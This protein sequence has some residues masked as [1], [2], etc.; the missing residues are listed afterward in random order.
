MYAPRYYGYRDYYGHRDYHY[1][2]HDYSHYM[3]YPRVPKN[4]RIWTPDA[5]PAGWPSWWLRMDREGRSGNN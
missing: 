5:Y 3:L 2:Y 1:G 4:D